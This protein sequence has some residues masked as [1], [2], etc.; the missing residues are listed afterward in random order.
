MR[1]FFLGVVS[2][3]WL[4]S[5]YAQVGPG[6]NDRVVTEAG[7]I[8]IGMPKVNLENAGFTKD[9]L[10][11]YNK[12]DNQE[13]MTFLDISLVGDNITFYIEDGIIKDWFRGTDMG[14]LEGTVEK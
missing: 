5:G 7:V 12:Y 9:K 2:F 11:S 8:L 1:Y 4:S 3:F 6:D 13:Y 10:I 14:T